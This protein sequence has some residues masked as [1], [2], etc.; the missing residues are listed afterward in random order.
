[1]RLS[2]VAPEARRPRTPWRCCDTHP[3]CAAFRKSRRRDRNPVSG[4]ALLAPW[5][6]TRPSSASAH[7]KYSL[8]TSAATNGA[9][10]I[11]GN[12]TSVG[13]RGR[14]LVD[15]L[16]AVSRLA[17]RSAVG[18][19]WIAATPTAIRSWCSALPADAVAR[20]RRVCSLSPWVEM[21]G[22]STPAST[23]SHRASHRPV[24]SG[25]TQRPRGPSDVGTSFMARRT[26]SGV[27][28]QPATSL[29]RSTESGSTP[30]CSAMWG[31]CIRYWVRN[32]RQESTA[33]SGS[34]VVDAAG[35]DLGDVH[36]RSKGRMRFSTPR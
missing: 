7:S 1:M 12:T 5:R 36:T 10:K 16:A 9:E 2:V 29:I 34:S 30:Q 31:C 15:Q 19:S 35:H 3:G 13:A 27:A 21:M 14:R 17:D 25:R 24:R 23:Y 28:G 8:S 6:W 32:A 22:R 11:S 18:W 33:A 4:R 20:A 26:S